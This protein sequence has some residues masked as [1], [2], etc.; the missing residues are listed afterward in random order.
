MPPRHT[1]RRSRDYF[2]PGLTTLLTHDFHRF[3]NIKRPLD[4][5]LATTTNSN[6]KTQFLQ[7]PNRRF[8]YG[9]ELYPK[10]MVLYLS[11]ATW[12]WCGRFDGVEGQAEGRLPTR[13]DFAL[14]HFTNWWIIT[15]NQ[16][17]KNLDERRSSDNLAIWKNASR[18]NHVKRR[19][20]CQILGGVH[21][22]TIVCHNLQVL[23]DYMPWSS[24]VEPDW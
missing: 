7:I 17:G 10:L 21:M 13:S 5:L 18:S 3:D 8:D 24:R 22:G 23:E 16:P 14:E 6:S 1:R 11:I 9:Q 15:Y 20:F 12:G 4:S 2:A 19:G